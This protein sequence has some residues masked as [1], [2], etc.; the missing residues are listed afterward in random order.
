MCVSL[1]IVSDYKCHTTHSESFL[2][3]K[4]LPLAD[5]A[6][7]SPQATLELEQPTALI[8][9]HDPDSPMW[10]PFPHILPWL[11]GVFRCTITK[12]ALMFS[13]IMRNLS[14]VNL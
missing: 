12:Q 6:N 8:L 4:A 11:M 1:L 7:P 2:S 3:P 13:V 14:S 5:E 9:R 10:L